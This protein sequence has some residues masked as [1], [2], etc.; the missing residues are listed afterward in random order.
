[1]SPSSHSL[2]SFRLLAILL[3]AA[4]CSISSFAQQPKVLAPHRPLAPRIEK[5]L[6]WTN[7]MV[8]QY[9]TGGLWMTDADWKASLYLKNGLKADP[10]TVTPVLYLSNGQRYPLSPVVL[11][12]SGTAIVDIGQ[13]LA[14]V[15]IAPYA[16]LCGYAEIEY[17]WPW[18][19]VTGTVK[20]VDVVNSLIF[21]FGLQPTP[22][23]HPEHMESMPL[24]LPTSFEGL[25]WKQERD[26]SGFL[27]LSNVTGQAIHA[28]VRLTDKS[29]TQLASYQVTVSPHG[30]KMLTLDE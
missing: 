30:T 6:P 1:M 16:T 2:S 17:Q 4:L 20:N 8:R 5:R 12:P 13:G 21:I 22:D 14:S 7:Q 19:A 29:D 11:E 3:A 24:T 18:A 26:I 23:W 28:A 25:W 10:V 15:G 27:A 9:A